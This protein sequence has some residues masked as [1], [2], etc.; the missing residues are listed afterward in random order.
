[1]KLTLEMLENSGACTDG[2]ELY[3]NA[4]CPDTV[5][6]TIQLCIKLRTYQ[7]ANWLLCYIALSPRQCLLYIQQ[8][9]KIFLPFLEVQIESPLVA[10]T[11]TRSKNIL[12]SDAGVE[13]SPRAYVFCWKLTFTADCYNDIEWAKIIEYGL[14]LTNNNKRKAKWVK[15]D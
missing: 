15:L 7:Y 14:E 5:E 12:E 6:E 9:A 13:T 10:S 3:K 11:I 2:I 1:M 4:G 8:V